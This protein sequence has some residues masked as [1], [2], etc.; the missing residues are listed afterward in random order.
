MVV[1]IIILIEIVMNDN[2]EIDDVC[3]YTLNYM[4]NSIYMYMNTYLQYF[5][6]TLLSPD[7]RELNWG[8]PFRSSPLNN[9]ENNDYYDDDNDDEDNNYDNHNRL[10]GVEL[11][12]T[13]QII[14]P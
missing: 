5:L 7:S 14:P 10:K 13:I 9:D 8:K 6:D 1:V 2:D 12:E 3:K 11:K 4:P